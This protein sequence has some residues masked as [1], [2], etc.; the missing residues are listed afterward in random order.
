VLS[1]LIVL[2]SVRRAKERAIG[3]A[4][5]AL[6]ASVVPGQALVF[7]SAALVALLVPGLLVGVGRA[8]GRIDVVR[9]QPLQRLPTVVAAESSP[10]PSAT[11]AAVNPRAKA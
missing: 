11:S 4:R 2:A 8:V 1:H 3:G 6:D 5:A 10:Q 7:G 9:D